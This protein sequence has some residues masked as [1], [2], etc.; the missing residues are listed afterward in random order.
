MDTI[1]PPLH[2]PKLKVPKSYNVCF[3]GVSP[4]FL[5]I[6]AAH[7]IIPSL[8]SLARPPRDILVPVRRT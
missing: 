4:G 6:L 8:L 2:D 1:E 3:N 5:S 7:P